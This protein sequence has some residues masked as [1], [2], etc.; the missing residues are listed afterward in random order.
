V[1]LLLGLLKGLLDANERD[2]RR[3][4]KVVDRINGFEEAMKACSHDELRGRTDLFRERLAQGETLDD[5]LPEAFAAVREAAR[6]T[7]KLR[8]YD[9]QMIGG[10][11]LHQGRL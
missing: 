6:R 4:R 1:I 11:V 5:L 8:H 7:L 9:V 2:V 10:I 3:M